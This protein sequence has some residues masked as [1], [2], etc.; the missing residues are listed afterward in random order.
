MRPLPSQKRRTDI[1]AAEERL[2]KIEAALFLWTNTDISDSIPIKVEDIHAA[3]LEAL[4]DTLIGGG[5]IDDSVANNPAY[6][7]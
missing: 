6:Q 7:Q 3:W 4:R 2:R 5:E 1:A